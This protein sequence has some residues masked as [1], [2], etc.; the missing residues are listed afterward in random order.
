LNHVLKKRNREEGGKRKKK[1]NARDCCF[2]GGFERRK[3]KKRGEGRQERGGPLFSHF[4][5][6]A[7]GAEAGA[8]KF[9]RG[10]TEGKRKKKIDNHPVKGSVCRGKGKGKK[11][12]KKK[13]RG[14]TKRR[15]WKGQFTSF[16]SEGGGEESMKNYNVL[17]GNRGKKKEREQIEN[18]PN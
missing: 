4:Q 5:K 15:K 11:K 2:G 13:K 18:R 1:E 3:K 7:Y 6:I 9:G 16:R 14:G 17:R 12:G 10:G 8:R